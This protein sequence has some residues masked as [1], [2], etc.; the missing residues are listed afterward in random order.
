MPLQILETMQ[1]LME[2]LSF[3]TLLLVAIEEL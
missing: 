2:N 1:I 3:Q